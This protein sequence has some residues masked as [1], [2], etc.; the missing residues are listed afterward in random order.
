MSDDIYIG[1]KKLAAGGLIYAK[2]T[3]NILLLKRSAA[4]DNP[5][6]WSELSGGMQVLESQIDTIER[7]ASEELG[8]TGA[9]ECHAVSRNITNR[10]IYY[11]YLIVV[12]QEFNPVLQWEHTSYK[13]TTFDRLPQPIHPKLISKLP[14]YKTKIDRLFGA[15]NEIKH[16]N[17]YFV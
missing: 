9:L 15:T 2:D 16:Y 3:K 7:E 8:Y 1:K 14:L 10:V 11:G 12:P 5:F 17:N 13:W 6:F 4:V